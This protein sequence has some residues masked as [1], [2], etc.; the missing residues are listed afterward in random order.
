MFPFYDRTDSFTGDT[1]DSAAGG[2]GG[3]GLWAAAGI[4]F[5]IRGFSWEGKPA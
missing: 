5:A 3:I 2:L 4:F 1:S